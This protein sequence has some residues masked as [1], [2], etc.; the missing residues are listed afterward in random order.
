VSFFW[1]VL[2]CPLVYLGGST[3]RSPN[4]TNTSLIE[5]SCVL[6]DQFILKIEDG[7]RY[8]WPTKFISIGCLL[9]LMNVK[10][11]SAA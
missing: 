7:S 9:C 4:K 2:S 10:M 6:S 3:N 5:M 8:L 1:L 11:Q